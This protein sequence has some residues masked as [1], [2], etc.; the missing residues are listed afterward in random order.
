MSMGTSRVQAWA[1]PAV[2]YSVKLVGCLSAV[3][4]RLCQLQDIDY[5][6]ESKRLQTY[7]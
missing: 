6:S 1:V 3:K 7:A 4:T 5:S 2:A